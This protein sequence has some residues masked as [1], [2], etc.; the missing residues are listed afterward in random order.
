[1]PSGVYERGGPKPLAVR[2][3]PKVDKAGDCW[4]WTGAANKHGR[5]Q[6]RHDGR[7]ILATHAA[8]L[9][10]YGELPTLNVC[11]TCD[12][13]AC[14]NPDH[15]FLGTQADNMRDML[16]KGRHVSGYGIAK[17]RLKQ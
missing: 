15:L 17:R 8:W 3:W 6:I 5:G 11:H 14:V 7:L 16:K 1:M 9:L 12:N 2:F 13:P 10:H 4:L